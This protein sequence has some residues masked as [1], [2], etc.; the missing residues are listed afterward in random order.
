M[1]QQTQCTVVEALRDL[2]Q[3]SQPACIVPPDGHV[4]TLGV[5]HRT[6]ARSDTAHRKALLAYMHYSCPNSRGHQVK[7]KCKVLSITL[8]FYDRFHQRV[9][10]V[11]LKCK[12]LTY[13]HR[14]DHIIDQD[15]K[16]IS[17]FSTTPLHLL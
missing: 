12:I 2:H 16:P 1:A 6:F 14:Y 8:L 17:R 5:H 7:I 4:Q 13:K 9:T 15:L 10:R 11:M 3:S